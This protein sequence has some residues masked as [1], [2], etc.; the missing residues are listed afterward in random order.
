MMGKRRKNKL[1]EFK[2]NN[3]GYILSWFVK[4]LKRKIMTD[5][6]VF[7]GETYEAIDF[8]GTDP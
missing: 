3:L 2:S 8:E 5:S 7:Q 1:E 4:K 6:W